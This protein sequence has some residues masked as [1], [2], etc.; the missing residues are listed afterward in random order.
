MTIVELWRRSKSPKSEV[1]EINYEFV[2]ANLSQ[3]QAGDAYVW[4]QRL[5]AKPGPL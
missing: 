1:Y 2:T 3:K 5:L 4:H